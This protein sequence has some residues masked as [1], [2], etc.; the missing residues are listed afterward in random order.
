VRKCF[1]FIVVMCMIIGAICVV[2]YGSTRRESAL[3]NRTMPMLIDE[4]GCI[5]KQLGFLLEKT[6]IVHDGSLASIVYATQKPQEEG[7]WLRAAGT[8][9]WDCPYRSIEESLLESID[10]LGIIKAVLPKMTTYDYAV[11]FGATAPAIRVR[12]AYLRT[13]YEQGI[14]FKRLVFLVGKRP[15]NLKVESDEVL[16]NFHN[17]ILAF[18][19]TWQFNGMFPETETDVARFVYD[20]SIVSDE[21]QGI[22]VTFVDTP[23]RFTSDGTVQCPTTEDTVIA[24]RDDGSLMPGTILAISSQ[25]YVQ[26]QGFI[27]RMLMP[28]TYSVD[29]V[30]PC[31]NQKTFNL[32]VLLDSLARD[33]YTLYKVQQ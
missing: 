17:A 2:G 1:E 30:G 9:R 10:E 4:Q 27:V 32:S 18:N 5:S 7:G 31:V 29:C 14:R 15:R 23:M 13:L 21:W 24:W 28:P 20:Q 3:Q 22:P 12:L 8:E 6:G 11:I 16:L 25:P 26:R 33:L 19:V